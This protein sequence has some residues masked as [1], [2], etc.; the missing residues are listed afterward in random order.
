ME[1]AKLICRFLDPKA[2]K[3]VFDE[4]EEVTE[5]EEDA[6]LEEIAEHATGEFDLNKQ[7]DSRDLD[8]IERA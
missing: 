6:F 1:P 2:A 8:T 3:K 5:V 7:L 4:Q